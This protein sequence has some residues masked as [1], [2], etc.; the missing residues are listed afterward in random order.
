MPLVQVTLRS[1]RDEDQIRRLAGEVTRAVARVLG[2]PPAS[3]RVLVHELPP[4]RWFVAGSPLDQP[5][6]NGPV[7]G[8]PDGENQ[9]GESL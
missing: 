3:V 7:A 8:P 6:P 2:A 4:G 9:G 5:A 1:G